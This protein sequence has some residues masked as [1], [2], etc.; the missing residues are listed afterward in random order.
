MLRI[1][2]KKPQCPCRDYERCE[3]VDDPRTIR[4]HIFIEL[5]SKC[6]FNCKF[7]VYSL[8]KRKKMFIS[9]VFL[10]KI[11]KDLRKMKPIEYVMFS[12]L[13]EPMLHPKFGEACRL[14]K[15][16]GYRLVVTTNG[17]LLDEKM[18]DLPIDELYISLQTPTKKSF[19]LRKAG[20]LN[21]EEYAE[22]VFDFVRDVPYQTSIYL[23]LENK[24]LF[25]QYNG[26][27]DRK[28]IA[29][30]RK[31]K[32]LANKA[33]PNLRLTKPIPTTVK[34][35][36]FVNLILRDLYTWSNHV[37]QKDKRLVKA[38]SIQSCPYYKHH[39]NILSNGE[40]SFCCMDF[41]GKMSLGNIK[42]ES[43][44]GIYARKRRGIDLAEF[45]FCRICRGTLVPKSKKKI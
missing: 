6:N 4:K 1:I 27:I 45:P 7:C 23:F 21:F 42:K 15:E 33:F 5:T 14:V 40:V 3:C 35:S 36:P 10:E 25:P 26:L 44:K 9:I 12:A 39:I 17:S 34:I 32:K 41:D 29:S 18:K 31:I 11:L 8:S 30:I 43:L 13:G 38:K 37:I 16:Y 24:D 19:K 22:R 28:K 2:P 20:N